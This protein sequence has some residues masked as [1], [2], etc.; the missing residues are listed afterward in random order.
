[1]NKTKKNFFSTT[2]SVVKRSTVAILCMLL[3][4]LNLSSFAQESFPTSNDI[5]N[6][7]VEG[8]CRLF[9]LLGDTV[10]ND[11][12]YSKLYQFADTVLLEANIYK[13]QHTK[14]YIGAIRNEGQ[15]VFFKPA[16]WEH[17][18]ILLYDFGAKVGDTV[19]HNAWIPPYNGYYIDFEVC[20]DCYSIVSSITIDENN[21]KIYRVNCPYPPYLSWHDRWYEGIGSDKGVLFSLQSSYPDY[22]SM[23]DF[24][25]NC[26]KHNNTVKYLDNPKCNKCFCTATSI[27]ENSYSDMIKIFPNPTKDIINIDIPENINIKSISIYS[28]DGKLVK[29]NKYLYNS[30]QLDI[31]KLNIGSYILNIEIDNNNNFSKIIIKN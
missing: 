19:W 1:M 12:I 15:K 30:G 3:M 2:P 11:V 29:K 10:I 22:W 18:D 21:Q 20:L 6:E 14:G 7:S 23:E 27:I 26:F 13:D 5:W 8:H 17:F 25:L 31:N 24:K 16:I 9:G 28:I 4:G